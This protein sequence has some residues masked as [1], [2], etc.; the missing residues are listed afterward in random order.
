VLVLV[1]VGLESSTNCLCCGSTQD[2][3]KKKCIEV[4]VIG[5]QK[6][7]QNIPVKV[8]EKNKIG[9]TLLGNISYEHYW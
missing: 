8:M 3:E 2:Q 6:K 5:K 1:L 9:E 4:V 7:K